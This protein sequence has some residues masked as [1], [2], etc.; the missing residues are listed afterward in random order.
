MSRRGKHYT[1]AEKKKILTLY[2]EFKTPA[3]IADIL[4]ISIPGIYGY[5]RRHGH[6]RTKKEAAKVRYYAL[7]S[8]KDQ[9]IKDYL[10]GCSIAE[11]AEKNGVSF[12]TVQR[13]VKAAGHTRTISA[14]MDIYRTKKDPGLH[15]IIMEIGRRSYDRGTKSID[16]ARE[17]GVSKEKVNR[18][19]RIYAKKTA[20]A[21]PMAIHTRQRVRCARNL[22]KEG[23][24]IQEISKFMDIS[25]GRIGQYIN[26][27]H[28]IKAW[29][30]KPDDAPAQ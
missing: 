18:C 10:S 26:H 13:A 29:R 9:A 1:L 30:D 24:P 2:M 25:T 11:A 15:A 28:K 19:T 7:K 23:Y 21:T 3:E 5:L 4:G 16:L 14:A 22:H 20:F 17:Y 27:P 8:R 12:S 6:T